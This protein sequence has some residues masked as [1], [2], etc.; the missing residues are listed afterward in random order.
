MYLEFPGV[1]TYF[2]KTA[3]MAVFQHSTDGD[4][5]K[6]PST[7]VKAKSPNAKIPAEVFVAGIITGLNLKIKIY[8]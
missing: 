8:E 1:K 2:A 3:T 6:R 4:R 5:I 7:A